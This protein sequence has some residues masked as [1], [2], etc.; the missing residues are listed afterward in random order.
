[1]ASPSTGRAGGGPSVAAAPEAMPLPL[2]DK[3]SIVVL[4]LANMSAE[5]GRDYLADEI[6]KA[7]TSALS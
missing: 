5:A 6:I 7:V 3:P 2:P 4:P 1:M